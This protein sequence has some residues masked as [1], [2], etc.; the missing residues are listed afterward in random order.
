VF[1]D[2]SLEGLTA[3]PPGLITLSAALAI[4]ISAFC[5]CPGYRQHRAADQAGD[6]SDGKV[7]SARPRAHRGKIAACPAPFGAG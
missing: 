3:V 7:A 2:P 6:Y 5:L 1:C 4:F